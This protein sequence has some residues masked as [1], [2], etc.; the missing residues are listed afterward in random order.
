[1]S[2]LIENYQ[3]EFSPGGEPNIYTQ[4]RMDTG[5]YA[6]TSSPANKEKL[7]IHVIPSIIRSKTEFILTSEAWFYFNSKFQRMKVKEISNGMSFI[8]LNKYDFFYTS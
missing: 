3:N 6:S 2:H 4:H 7:K 5:N 1:M 8:C